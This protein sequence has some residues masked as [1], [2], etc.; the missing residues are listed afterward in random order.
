MDPGEALQ[1]DQQRPREHLP[2]VLFTAFEPSGDDHAAAVIAQLKRFQPDLPIYAWGGPRMEAAGATIIERTGEDAV[3]GVPGLAKISEHSNIN[4]RVKAW[5]RQT[6]GL[7]LHVPVDSPAAN[8]PICRIAKAEGLHVVHL[9][10]P[11][12]WAW[13]GWRIR[14]LKR[15]TDQLLCLLPFEEKW[16]RDR[17]ISAKFVGHPLF[18]SPL[19]RAQLSQACCGFGHGSPRIALLPGSRP[20][21]I[22]RNFP[23]LLDAY[24]ALAAAKPETR[25]VVAAT[26]EAVADR[27][28]ALAAHSGGWPDSLTVAVS[29]AD[30]VIHWSELAIVVSGTVTLQIARQQ[31]PMIIVYKSSP[32][33]YMLLARWVL[34]TEF[35]TLPNL[36][37]GREIVP[38]FVPHFGQ[39]EPIVAEALRIIDSPEVASRQRAEL[40]RIAEQFGG[41]QAGVEAASA[42]LTR[43]GLAP[44]PQESCVS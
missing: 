18:D 12:V 11:Q 19:P 1:T 40:A 10:A 3:M 29:K 27:V 41:H 13:G 42:I 37:A 39:H 2:G 34:S 20:S 17:G 25:G 8:F 24:R 30:A 28:R 26:T 43:L 21:E 44:I 9:V 16:F 33:F 36:V 14:K 38:E 4:R 35:L 5:I 7:R 22:A 23:L 31:R 15:L 32:L 6:P